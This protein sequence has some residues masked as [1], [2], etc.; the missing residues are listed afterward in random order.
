LR[1]C[2]ALGPLPFPEPVTVRA[3]LSR[4]KVSWQGME[5]GDGVRVAVNVAVAVGVLVRVGVAVCVKVAVRPLTGVFVLVDVAE[6]VAV[7]VAVT[8]GEAVSVAVEVDRAAIGPVTVFEARNSTIRASI[9]SAN[10]QPPR[11]KVSRKPD[12]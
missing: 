12:R 1:N 2:A 4:T 3:C 5:V 11:E 7:G 9:R 8:V 10:S 6:G